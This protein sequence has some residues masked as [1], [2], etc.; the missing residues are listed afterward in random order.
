MKHIDHFI[1]CAPSMLV[2]KRT[3]SSMRVINVQEYDRILY[4]QVANV[5]PRTH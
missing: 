5:I 4:S 2:S 3:V 1:V